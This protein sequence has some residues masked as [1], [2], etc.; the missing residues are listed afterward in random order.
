MSSA[1]RRRAQQ[2]SRHKKRQ[3]GTDGSQ[4]GPTHDASPAP[5][6]P[7]P[8]RVFWVPL[9]LTLG[10]ALLSFVPRVS[11]NTTLARS[12]WGAAIVLLVWQGVLFLRVKGASEGRSL[13]TVLR[14]QHYL[15]ALVQLAVFA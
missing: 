8:R 2:G 14:P 11:G 1:R 10:L 13:S 3:Q 7:S 5:R 9:A 4:R 15:Q 6:N 12:F